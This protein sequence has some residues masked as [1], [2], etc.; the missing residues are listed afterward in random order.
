MLGMDIFKLGATT[1]SEESAFQLAT[2]TFC[3]VY[4]YTCTLPN[5]FNVINVK[6]GEVRH[7]LDAQFIYVK[8]F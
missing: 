5:C 3:L 2:T 7:D 8:R 4:P 1:D 6:R